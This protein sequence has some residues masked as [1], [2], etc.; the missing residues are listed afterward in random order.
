MFYRKKNV[1]N[2]YDI[3]LNCSLYVKDTCMKKKIATAKRNWPVSCSNMGLYQRCYQRN[4]GQLLT[5]DLDGRILFSTVH[6]TC[7]VMTVEFC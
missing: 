1:L 5:T 2:K 6:N 3:K 7:R 4:R